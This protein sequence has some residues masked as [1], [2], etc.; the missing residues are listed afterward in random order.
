MNPTEPTDRATAPDGAASALPWAESAALPVLEPGT[1][2]QM[3]DDLPEETFKL[4]VREAYLFRAGQII[5]QA[6]QDAKAR[7]DLVTASRPPFLVLR[8][9]EPRTPSTSNSNRPPRIAVRAHDDDIA[10]PHG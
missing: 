1:I 8:V 4:I 5:V 6:M 9:P 10:E 2:G 7:Y 3:I